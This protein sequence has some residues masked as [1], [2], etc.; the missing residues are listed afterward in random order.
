MLI[1]ESEDILCSTLKMNCNQLSS[2]LTKFQFRSSSDAT[3][4]ASACPSQFCCKA[5]IEHLPC[6]T[7]MRAESWSSF[8]SR[9]QSSRPAAAEMTSPPS[10]RKSLGGRVVGSIASIVSGGRRRNNSLRQSNSDVSS[11]T[12]YS[13]HDIQGDMGMNYPSTSSTR[14]IRH[15]RSF[16]FE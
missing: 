6:I 3:R 9:Y 8:H 11:R 15:S 4:T 16:P 1:Y 5:I 10:A 2:A 7:T 14:T 12:I 13:L